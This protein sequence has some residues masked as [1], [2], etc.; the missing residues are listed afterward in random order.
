MRQRGDTSDYMPV[1][2]VTDEEKMSYLVRKVII[3]APEVLQGPHTL[4]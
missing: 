4:H 3:L 2:S 1:K